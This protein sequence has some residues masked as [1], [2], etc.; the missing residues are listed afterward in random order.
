MAVC[1]VCMHPFPSGTNPVECSRC[2]HILDPAAKKAAAAPPP[3]LEE[4]EEEEEE[5]LTKEEKKKKKAKEKA[6]KAKEKAKKKQA[7]KKKMAKLKAP[8]APKIK[9]PTV[10]AR[11][12]KRRFMMV[13]M[14]FLLPII[15]LG[16][17]WR[18]MNRYIKKYTGNK[19]KTKVESTVKD[20]KSGETRSGNTIEPSGQTDS[21]NAVQSGNASSDS[22]HVDSG[23][24]QPSDGSTADTSGSTS[25]GTTGN[26][27]TGSSQ[28]PP[29]NVPGDTGGTS[30]TAG[31][32]PA[33]QQS[34]ESVELMLERGKALYNDNQH[35]AC[36]DLMNK[37]LQIQP[38]GELA[39]QA[40]NYKQMSEQ[41]LRARGEL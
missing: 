31:A 3:A 1:P 35:L 5:P 22:T 14:G 24:Y 27:S 39:R 7:M 20:G 36:M 25:S 11:Q 26:S 8:R 28:P 10:M 33:V 37:V 4:E 23:G 17:V 6:A 9:D 41:I 40:K 16:F 21:G 19:G 32:A 30:T 29:G 13:I 12:A 18:N 38:Y 2:G 34:N 15:M